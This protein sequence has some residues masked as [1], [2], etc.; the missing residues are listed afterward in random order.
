MAC[1]KSFP[2]KIFQ[3]FEFS[4]AICM[5]IPLRFERHLLTH[6]RSSSRKVDLVVNKRK[7]FER[8]NSIVV[9]DTHRCRALNAIKCERGRKTV[10][11]SNFIRSF[12][13]KIDNSK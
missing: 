3:T 4:N 9:L 8:D 1:G 7:L 5:W 10:L 2:L 6:R 13:K 11:C 12:K